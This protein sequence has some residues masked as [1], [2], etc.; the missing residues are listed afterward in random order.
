MSIG[1]NVD[2]PGAVEFFRESPFQ[3][4]YFLADTVIFVGSTGISIYDMIRHR[5]QL[6]AVSEVVLGAV[7][8]GMLLLWT[9]ALQAHSRLHK[10]FQAGGIR[11]LDSGSALEAAIK[12]AA[13]MIHLG[14]FYGFLLVALLVMQVDRILMG[15]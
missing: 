14:M 5:N 15:R 9:S 7:I 13:S 2:V 12:V 10:V 4:A 11:E 8:F 6:S 3:W 1:V